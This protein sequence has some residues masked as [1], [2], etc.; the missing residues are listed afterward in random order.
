MALGG[1]VVLTSQ[2]AEQARSSLPGRICRYRPA[3]I[4]IAILL[5]NPA[6]AQDE[7][8]HVEA[9]ACAFDRAELERLVRLEL[10]TVIRP[11]ESASGYRVEL[12]CSPNDLLLRIEDPITRKTV[13]RTVRIPGPSEPEPERLVAL[14]VAQLYRAAWLEL[15]ADDP[16]PLEPSS[17]PAPARVTGRARREVRSKV[18]DSSDDARTRVVLRLNASA[19]GLSHRYV[20]MRGL[21]LEIAHRPLPPLVLGLDGQFESGADQRDSGRVEARLAGGHISAA[22][23]PSL[24][25]PVTG[26]F[27]AD[28]GLLHLAL[29]GTE[30]GRTSVSGRVSGIGF[31]ASLG[32][33][34]AVDVEPIRIAILGR[35][36]VISGAPLGFVE[37]DVP[38]D[39][40]G[41]WVGGHLDA[42]VMF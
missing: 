4:A 14:S 27:D 3:W 34:A 20:T 16:P 36:G 11:G 15:V 28:A 17:P 5:P 31:D 6:V 8:V 26:V 12:T 21:G 22:F 25:G 1:D 23:E 32:L 13:E 19:R 38:V 2:H 24:F 39:F 41:V 9:T 33:G 35:A 18:P 42:G 40:N 7:P 30:V 37:D 10:G 29:E